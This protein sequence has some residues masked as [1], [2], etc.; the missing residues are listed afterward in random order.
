MKESQLFAEYENQ[1]LEYE[2]NNSEIQI[3]QGEKIIL[4]RYLL[5]LILLQGINSKSVTTNEVFA[6]MWMG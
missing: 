4:K 1:L 2:K 3:K 5:E 6:S